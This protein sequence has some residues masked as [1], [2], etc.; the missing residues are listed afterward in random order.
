M[1][2]PQLVHDDDKD[3]FDKICRFV[4]DMCSLLI[5]L[6]Q[7]GHGGG[8][9]N[10]TIFYFDYTGYGTDRYEAYCNDSWP[11]V[12]P[13]ERRLVIQANMAYIVELM[14]EILLH[15]NIKILR[16]AAQSLKSE[17]Q[18]H[19]VEKAAR[20]DRMV[21]DNSINA[22]G[23]TVFLPTD[24]KSSD[25]LDATNM[26]QYT[27]EKRAHTSEQLRLEMKEIASDTSTPRCTWEELMLNRK[28]EGCWVEVEEVRQ[29]KCSFLRDWPP[30]PFE[31]S[32]HLGYDACMTRWKQ[33]QVELGEELEAQVDS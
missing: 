28:R 23:V 22:D 4:N 15:I 10:M 24:A 29:L 12:D 19:P 31:S 21:V 3:E 7:R 5:Q 13:K 25:L 18:K 26:N 33:Q 6:V 8:L 17:L 32:R 20:V 11:G 1:T 14:S 27:L 30:H 9:G 16:E 2:L